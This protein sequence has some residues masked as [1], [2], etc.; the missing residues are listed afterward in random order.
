[1]L[2]L[3]ACAIG[4]ETPP[5]RDAS[6]FL[7][8]DNGRVRIG[9]K[10]SSGAGIAWLSESG[11]TRNVINHW[12]RGR[13]IQQSYYGAEDGSMWNKTPWRWNP[14]QGGDWRGKPAT[15][16]ELRST[17]TSLYARSRARHWASGADMEDVIFEEWIQ[18]KD[19][20]A[21]VHFRM[22]Y[23]GSQSHPSI[24][25][26]I[27]AL[28]FSPELDTLVA[29]DG[30]APWTHGMLSR[31]K[32]GWPN[33]YRAM[34]E[35]WAAYVDAAGFGAGA[36]VPQA[37]RLTCYRYGDGREDHGSCSY[38]APLTR[39]PITPG[40]RFDYEVVLTLGTVDEIRARFE[41]VHRESRH[42]G[43]STPAT[44]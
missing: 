8:L 38:F 20:L 11:S 27:P 14:V 6:D 25:H 10:R 1:M 5:E 24:D 35:S 32:P 41:A 13:L 15:V 43:I 18:L 26:E 40:T 9:V 44:P 2:G 36:Y 3:A 31:S 21:R 4:A 12:D 19:R 17:R 39:F 22:T 28:F 37:M 33:E 29:Y 7:F 34:A 23:S 30:G 16:L 42:S